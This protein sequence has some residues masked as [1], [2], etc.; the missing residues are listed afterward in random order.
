[1]SVLCYLTWYYPI[2]LFRNSEWTNAVNERGITMF[3]HIWVF[4]VFS[5]TFAHM[6]IAGLPSADI[7]GGVVG[8]LLIMMFTFCG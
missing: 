1:M 5:S 4:F 2:G 8:L 7:A 6:M 3:L